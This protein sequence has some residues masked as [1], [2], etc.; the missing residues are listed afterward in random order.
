MALVT[1]EAHTGLLISVSLGKG[2]I[3]SGAS[4]VNYIDFDPLWIGRQEFLPPL[5]G[6]VQRTSSSWEEMGSLEGH[7]ERNAPES[8]PASYIQ[9]EEQTRSPG[10][11]EKKGK[12][13]VFHLLSINL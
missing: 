5:R 8:L 1:P 4:L 3:Q 2:L 11:G 13:N 7:D 10:R 6:Q 9:Q 12:K